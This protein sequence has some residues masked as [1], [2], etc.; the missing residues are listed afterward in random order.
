MSKTGLPVIKP[1]TAKPPS[2]KERK[3]KLD[4]TCVRILQ[5]YVAFHGTYGKDA[6]IHAIEQQGRGN[7]WFIIRG[8]T[9]PETGKD[10]EVHVDWP[11][12]RRRTEN[13]AHMGL[14]EWVDKGK[15]KTSGFRLNQNGYDFLHGV[16]MVRKFSIFRG[17]WK[18]VVGQYGKLITIDEVT[19]TLTD[20]KAG[21]GLDIDF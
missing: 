5:L 8:S 11:D 17:G 15:R 13:M 4:T 3:F 1:P 19:D 6:V 7:G 12:P 21:G 2:G 14:F 9:D 20:R 18:G 10:K 16:A